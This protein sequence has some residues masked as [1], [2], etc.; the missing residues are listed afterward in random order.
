MLVWNTIKANR[1]LIIDNQKLTMIIL[2]E[3]YLQSHLIKNLFEANHKANDF[4]KFS[5]PLLVPY[6]NSCKLISK[7]LKRIHVCFCGRFQDV[8]HLNKTKG[9]T[10]LSFRNVFFIN[11]IFSV[12]KIIMITVR[13]KLNL[14]VCKA[15]FLV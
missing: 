15:D 14:R 8:L 1:Q 4:H 5:L 13:R 6:V 7:Y 12:E 9:I 2:L 3:I 10:S 11:K